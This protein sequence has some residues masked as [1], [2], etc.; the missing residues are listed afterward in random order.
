MDT[1]KRMC[2]S[3]SGIIAAMLPQFHSCVGMYFAVIGDRATDS[4]SIVSLVARCAVYRLSACVMH[5]P[6]EQ[7]QGSIDYS[8]QGTSYC[9]L[10]SL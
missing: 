4:G 1:F 8:V 3:S 2:L 7:S 10:A 9:M 6:V 5:L